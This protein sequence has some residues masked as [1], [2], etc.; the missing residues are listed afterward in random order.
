MRF[1]IHRAF[2]LCSFLTLFGCG[3]DRSY[4]PLQVQLALPTSESLDPL[5]ADDRLRFVRV[6]VSGPEAGDLAT[7]DLAAGASSASFE[8]FPIPSDDAPVRTIDV[9][10]QGFDEFGNQLAYGRAVGVAFEGETSV[11]VPFR[12]SLAYVSHQAICGFGCGDEAACVEAGAGFECRP[13][14]NECGTC[15]TGR[16]CVVV[17]GNNQRCRPVWSGTTAGPAHIYVLDAFSR[18]LVERVPVPGAAPR[19]LEL[20]AFEGEAVVST[21]LEGGRGKIGILSTSDHTWRV[22]EVTDPAG[23]ALSPTHAALGRAQALGV[24]AGGGFIIIF[25]AQS[26]TTVAGRVIPGSVRD[27]A[28]GLDGTRAVVVVNQEPYVFLVDLS[29]P[30]GSSAISSPATFTGGGGVAISEDGRLA[31]VT[32]DTDGAVLVIDLLRGVS[33]AGKGRFGAAVRQVAYSEYTSSL[34]AVQAGDDASSVR[35]ALLWTTDPNFERGYG[36]GVG[37]F[38]RASG[39]AG[40]P[41]GRRALI[42]SPSTSTLSASLTSIDLSRDQSSPMSPSKGLYPSDPE[43]RKVSGVRPGVDCQGFNTTNAPENCRVY[44][45]Q[46]YQ[47]RSITILYGS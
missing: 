21:L 13:L 5:R 7:A 35:D 25:D 4:A 37:R 41:G 45:H 16:A 8:S 17:A 19:A 14:A 23:L 9:L 33:R 32:S 36:S 38:Q 3:E 12:R 26:F 44:E 27:L 34:L 1:S 18:N 10:A 24:A 39:L 42:V 47:P 40:I 43:E 29:D 6:T 22:G 11:S 20:S 28:V 15:G 46:R 2:G 31:Y 30:T